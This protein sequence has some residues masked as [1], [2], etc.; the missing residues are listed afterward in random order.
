[1]DASFPLK[2]LDSLSKCGSLTL[3]GGT[4][5]TRLLMLLRLFFVPVIFPEP[6]LRG[7]EAGWN[8]AGMPVYT[9]SALSQS[10]Q[11]ELDSQSRSCTFDKIQIL[12][13]CQPLLLCGSIKSSCLR[14]EIVAAF[15]APALLVVLIR[16]SPSTALFQTMTSA[17]S[18]IFSRPYALRGLPSL[19]LFADAPRLGHASFL[20]PFLVTD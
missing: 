8:I 3:P 5:R 2:V 11:Y 13:Q 14:L 12:S 16:Q 19:Q 4:S 10:P 7:R 1:M 20:L 15:P 6:C 9:F 17:S 18:A